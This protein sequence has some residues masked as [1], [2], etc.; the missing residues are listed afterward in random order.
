MFDRIPNTP[1]KI[2]LVNILIQVYNLMIKRIPNSLNIFTKKDKRCH[3]SIP[4]PYIWPYLARGHQT[5]T[6]INHEDQ[7]YGIVSKCLGYSLECQGSIFPPSFDGQL[8]D[9]Q[10]HVLALSN[11]W[12]VCYTPFQVMYGELN[13][14]ATRDI[15]RKKNVDL[16]F[17]QV[18]VFESLASMRKIG[19]GLRTD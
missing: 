13:A 17:L 2:I 19:L 5:V 12:M 4:I 8:P 10:S 16:I 6:V 7:I 9:L 18:K 1:L 15:S 11:Q 14:V 3:V